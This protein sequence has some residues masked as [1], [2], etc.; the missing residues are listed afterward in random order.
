MPLDPKAEALLANMPP[1]VTGNL[2]EARRQFQQ[3]AEGLESMFPSPQVAT[4]DVLVSTRYGPRAVRRYSPTQVQWPYPVVFFHGGGFVLGDLDSHHGLAS[5]ISHTLGAE[6][7]SVDYSLA[8]EAKLP[9]AVQECF[10]ATVWVSSTAADWGLQPA[11]VVAGDSAGGNFATV[12]AQMARD[13]GAP[14]IVAQVLYY[15]V[16]DMTTVT[17]SRRTFSHGYF[18]TEEAVQWFGQQYLTDPQDVVNPLASPAL[19]MDLTGLAPALILTGEYDPLRDEGE[20]YV[21]QL[22]DAGVLVRHVRYDGMIHGFMSMPLFD[23]MQAGLDVTK[24]FL[25]G[26]LTA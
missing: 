4:H 19:A 23:Q 10:D 15:P 9:Q 12:I 13:H 17:E 25:E 24:D 22:R 16:V 11:V 26:L 21:A 20:A 5:R 2:H 14:S 8:P 18:L 3:G 7:F 6:V 1:L